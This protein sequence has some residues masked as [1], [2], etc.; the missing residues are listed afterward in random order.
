MSCPVM[1]T[2]QPGSVHGVPAKLPGMM[3]VCVC[4]L[5]D[6]FSMSSTFCKRVARECESYH[7]LVALKMI[8]YSN[9]FEH[10]KNIPSEPQ[11]KSPPP[12][13]PSE[14]VV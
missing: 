3:C 5:E 9:N 13:Y 12:T 1:L 8:V 7:T 4:W 11:V 2:L 14:H 10:Q 6:G